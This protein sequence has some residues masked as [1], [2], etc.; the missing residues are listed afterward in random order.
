[1]VIGM[2]SPLADE[3][4]SARS[5]GRSARCLVRRRRLRLWLHQAQSEPAFVLGCADPRSHERSCGR[6]DARRCHVGGSSCLGCPGEREVLRW[7][8]FGQSSLGLPTP[9]LQAEIRDERGPLV[10]RVDFLF[11]AQRTIVEFDGLVKY[12]G[13]DGRQAL[14][15]QKRREDGVRAL[16]YQIVRP[17]WRDLDDPPRLGQEVRAAFARAMA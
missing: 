2:P 9:E 12:A 16:G 11:R 3:R 6:A 4:S 14:I 15:A 13:A 5:H 17:T 1:M 8:A 7:S 10:G